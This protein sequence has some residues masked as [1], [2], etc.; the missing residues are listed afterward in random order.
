MTL[1]DLDLYHLATDDPLLS[2]YLNGGFVNI[3]AGVQDPPQGIVIR[4]DDDPLLQLRVHDV[5]ER[6]IGLHVTLFAK[7]VVPEDEERTPVW[8]FTD[9]EDVK[10]GVAYTCRRLAVARYPKP[11]WFAAHVADIAEGMLRDDGVACTARLDDDGFMRFEATRNG[12]AEG[13]ELPIAF[14]LVT[15]ELVRDPDDVS[16]AQLGA[17]EGHVD[18]DGTVRAAAR[19]AVQAYD[20]TTAALVAVATAVK[21][22]V[23]RQA[24]HRMAE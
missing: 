19:G 5:S 6:G 16:W 14:R 1:T 3:Q 15:P 17:Q 8:R 13:A 4:Y 18:A 22:A 2:D 10:D 12:D 24:Q 20:D 21:T 7:H 9:L 11:A 23:E